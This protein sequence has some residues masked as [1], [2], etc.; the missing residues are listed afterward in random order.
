[1]V[2]LASPGALGYPAQR[3][4]DGLPAEVGL[5]AALTGVALVTTHDA[6]IKLGD[7]V[8]GSGLGAIGLLTVQLARPDGATTVIAVDPIEERRVLARQLGADD[9]IDPMTERVAVG[10]KQRLDGRGVACGAGT[11][12]ETS[13]VDG[14]LHEAIAAVR[15]G[16]TVVSAGSVQG[17]APALRLGEEWHH[18]RPQLVSS[19]G[20][21]DCAH[22]D[23][24]RWDRDRIAGT[25]LE[26]L[27]SGALQVE[28]LLGPSFAFDAASE[29]Y[30]LID[31]DRAPPVKVVLRYR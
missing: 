9:V 5:F 3:L 26:L 15:V 31:T 11:V 19:M 12:V 1:M 29:A 8:V 16:G 18:N 4:P 23:H 10:V 27:A 6:G 22:R 30:S 2:D 13:G 24:P 25:A 20:V 14:A 28:R 17:G 7:R 21:W